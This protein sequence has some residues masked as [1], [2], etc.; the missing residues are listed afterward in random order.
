MTE[1]RNKIAGWLAA[2]GMALV[3]A[4]CG[5]SDNDPPPS[6]PSIPDPAKR[7]DLVSVTT[8]TNVNKSTISAIVLLMRAAGIDSGKISATYDI[9]VS[10]IVYKTTAPD[11]RLIDAS[12]VVAYPLKV[13]GQASPLLSIQHGTIFTDGEAP[14]RDPDT[15][16]LVKVAAAT[17]YVAMMPDYIGYA[18][19]DKEVPTYVFQQGL[20]AAVID[21]IRATR[22]LMTRNNVAMNGQLFITGYSEGGYAT[23]AAQREIEQKFAQEF[24]LTASMPAAGPYDM[25]ATAQY[26]VGLA[27]NENPHYLGFV[28]KVYDHWLGWNRLNDMFQPPYNTVVNTFYDGTHSSGDIQRSLTSD[29]AALFKPEFR[30]AF[31][32]TGEP[33]VKAGF[34]ANDIYNW[35]PR[36]PTRLFHGRNDTI[37]PYAN[38]TTARD[39]MV[40]A[41]STSVS[42]VDCSRPPLISGDDHEV[43]VADYFTEM[44]DWF[45]SLAT[46]L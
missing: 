14:S 31:L 34:A 38:T 43:C 11:G 2:L 8:T 28:F 10:T 7:G 20:A 44:F 21:M 42:L 29:M 41:G 25:S 33:T 13:N 27:V 24:S 12:G 9:A 17:G 36:V 46:Q 1:Q 5:R 22:Q 4:S 30:T 19:S 16:N 23:L 45:G 35:A 40:R 3:L 15:Q 32:G 39:A 37:V 18:A 6:P 26:M